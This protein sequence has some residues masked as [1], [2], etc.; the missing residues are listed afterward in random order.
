MENIPRLFLILFLAAFSCQ[1]ESNSKELAEEKNEKS[2]DS[3]DAE[4][5]AQ[6]VVNEI[7]AHYDIINWAALATGDQ[8]KHAGLKQAA[9]KLHRT[10]VHL[11]DRWRVYAWKKNIVLPDSS[12][13]NSAGRFEEKQE[14]DS[15]RLKNLVDELLEREKKILARLEDYLADA[16]DPAL[17]LII[18][19]EMPDIRVRHDELMVLKSKL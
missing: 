1:D 15:T 18:Q 13:M 11:A 19:D 12:D 6:F 5:D 8:E 14:N 9:I 2:I 3:R 7:T 16:A 10:H 17:K 4:R